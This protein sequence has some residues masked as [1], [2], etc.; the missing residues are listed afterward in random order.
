MSDIAIK[1]MYFSNS[2]IKDFGTGERERETIYG[3]ASNWR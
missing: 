1:R 2:K 3:K